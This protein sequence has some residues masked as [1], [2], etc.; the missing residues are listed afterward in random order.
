PDE[1][2]TAL[3]DSARALAR[4]V[5]HGEEHGE[6][7]VGHAEELD[8]AGYDTEHN[9]KVWDTERE[10]VGASTPDDMPRG[11]IDLSM[12]EAEARTVIDSGELDELPDLEPMFDPRYLESVYVATEVVWRSE[13]ENEGEGEEGS[14]E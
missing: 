9:L 12:T 1:T 3:E 13:D 5:E 6:E 14:K 2:R 7:C 8:E 11:Y 4:A 10:L